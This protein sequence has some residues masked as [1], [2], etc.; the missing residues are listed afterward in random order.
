LPTRSTLVLAPL[1]A[2]SMF[3]WG[4][5]D[6]T[7]IPPSEGSPDRAEIALA[8]TGNGVDLVEIGPA[9]NA[10]LD[11]TV[12]REQRLRW[13]L[14]SASGA[15]LDAGEVPDP[16]SF[17]AEFDEHGTA[18]GDVGRAPSGVLTADVPRANG[19]LLLSEWDGSAWQLLG[20]TSLWL[21]GD[22]AT[23]SEGLINL[24]TDVIGEPALV[25]GDGAAGRVNLLILP[26]GY[27]EAELEVF[28][29]DADRA[30]QKLR[31][32]RAFDERWASLNFYRQDIRSAQSGVADPAT[33]T[34]PVTA[35]EMT[36]GKD[37]TSVP[38]RCVLPER[39][40]EARMLAAMKKLAAKVAADAVIIVAN[41]DEYG[42]CAQPWNGYVTTTK[43]Q[44]SPLIAAHELGH[45]LFKL[46]DEYGGSSC[47]SGFQGP[48][49]T[50]DLGAL[51]WSALVSTPQIPTPLTA[52]AGVIGAFE[53]AGYCDHGRY[54]PTHDCLMRNLNA[55]MCPVCAGHAARF[56]DERAGSGAGEATT[57]DVSLQNMTGA[58]VFVRCPDTI[59]AG[60]D[61]WTYV[62]EGATRSVATTSRG[63]AV[64]LDNSTVGTVPVLFRWRTVTPNAASATIYAHAED[65]LTPP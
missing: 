32:V 37:G 4:C 8:I 36:F 31:S 3:A 29:A 49:V 2:A 27:T 47:I 63:N 60:C 20:S 38:R 42:G 35:F 48:N 18:H 21:E 28:H 15:S 25:A 65:P 17:R 5:A 39:T 44:Y 33:S 57:G 43:N 53:G 23:R 62:A 51:P 55:Q 59:G 46:A 13:E 14:V 19:E 52:P 24:S 30:I 6:S 54:R 58:G 61:D 50:A 34:N 7:P 12:P 40:V 9:R 41:S 1:V 16:R 22:V 10:A 64:I 11:P 26:E 56:F 45:T